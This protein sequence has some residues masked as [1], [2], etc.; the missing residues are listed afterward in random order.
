M[1]IYELTVNLPTT[2]IKV[3]A[4]AEAL[5]ELDIIFYYAVKIFKRKYFSKYAD[6]LRESARELSRKVDKINEI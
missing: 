5:K 2:S 1:Q 6:K 4:S 3:Q